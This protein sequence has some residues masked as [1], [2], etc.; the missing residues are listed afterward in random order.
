MLKKL[1][2]FVLIS[3]G[4]L[5]LGFALLLFLSY[6]DYQLA[7][8]SG[9]EST[10]EMYAAREAG[11]STKDELS[12][13]LSKELGFESVSQMETAKAEGFETGEGYK[14]HLAEQQAQQEAEAARLVAEDETRREAEVTFPAGFI[15]YDVADLPTN[16]VQQA[17]CDNIEQLLFE[18]L[19][20]IASFS[21]IYS[22]GELVSQM[23]TTKYCLNDETFSGMNMCVDS[24]TKMELIFNDDVIRTRMVLTDNPSCTYLS[25]FPKAVG[26]IEVEEWSEGECRYPQP[27]KRA[28]NLL[29]A[30]E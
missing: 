19:E 20:K 28:A 3:V 9:F 30:L 7:K 21:I 2:R 11:F 29:C 13:H 16:L 17:S 15:S 8:E 5:A 12:N 18:Y 27:R 1:L 25:S 4:V 22:N 6:R 23:S 10:S 14:Q 26:I 24:L